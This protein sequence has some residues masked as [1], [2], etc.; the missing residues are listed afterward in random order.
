MYVIMWEFIVR[1]DC[2]GQ[3]EAIYGRQGDWATLF[4]KA[5]GYRETQL[6]RDTTNALRY[7][8]LDFWTSQEAHERFWHEHEREYTALDERC[9]RLTVKEHKLGEFL[10]GD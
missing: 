7:V 2:A 4:A 1:A 6:L 5:E 9:E 8:T 10:R 3:F